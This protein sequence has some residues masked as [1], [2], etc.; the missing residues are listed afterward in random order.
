MSPDESGFLA[1][2]IIGFLLLPVLIGLIAGA[3]AKEK[4]GKFGWTK[5]RNYFLVSL[6]VLILLRLLDYLHLF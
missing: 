2:E 3:I 6:A 1:G 4:D 5:A